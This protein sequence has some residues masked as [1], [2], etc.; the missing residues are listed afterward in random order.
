MTFTID[1]VGTLQG[2]LA[3]YSPLNPISIPLPNFTKS[4]D[5]IPFSKTGIWVGRDEIY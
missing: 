5:Q 1:S 3:P 4:I 2:A